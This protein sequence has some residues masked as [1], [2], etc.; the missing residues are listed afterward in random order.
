MK[1]RSK[2]CLV[3][4]TI[5]VNSW[6]IAPPKVDEAR[7]SKCPHCGTAGR[8][9]GD[10]LGMVG[11]GTRSRQIRGPTR[12]G[13]SPAIL[14]I[15]ARRYRCRGC[16]RTTTVVPRGVVPRRHYGAPAIALACFLLG[17]SGLTVA[18]VRQRVAPGITHEPGWAVVR[19]W[20]AAVRA[21]LLFPF[22][23][24]WPVDFDLPRRTERVATTVMAFAPGS[25]ANDEERLFAG[26]ALAA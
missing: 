6:F 22:V 19:R 17:V 3:H 11:H 14:V 25:Y 24:P 18:A 20:L 1:E 9:S 4:G 21:R 23:R 2:S 15:R 13:E 12:P 5:D 26:I 16:D 10:P 7:P 8:P